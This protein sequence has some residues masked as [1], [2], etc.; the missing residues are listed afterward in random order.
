MVDNAIAA[1]LKLGRFEVKQQAQ[2]KIKEPQIGQHLFG[3]NRLPKIT[4]P[5][6]TVRAV[7]GMELLKRGPQRRKSRGLLINQRSRF[8]DGGAWRRARVFP[9]A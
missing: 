2:R 4:L 7:N 1:L 5:G 3:I 8:L 6:E 9:H